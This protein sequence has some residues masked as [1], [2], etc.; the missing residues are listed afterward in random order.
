MKGGR[1]GKKDKQRASRRMGSTVH[2]KANTYSV[3]GP[4]PLSPPPPHRFQ[5][6]RA[7]SA[8]STPPPSANS[9]QISSFAENFWTAIS[10]EQ[11]VSASE[12]A[13]RREEGG[14]E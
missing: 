1:D 3:E 9:L 14:E 2:A 7:C 5:V 11:H 13:Y 12:A 6:C 10:V 4:A 8:T